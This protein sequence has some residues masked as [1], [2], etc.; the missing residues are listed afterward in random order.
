MKTNYLLLLAV[1]TLGQLQGAGAPATQRTTLRNKYVQDMSQL[2]KEARA[3][4]AKA[5]S[6]TDAAY[7]TQR[8]ALMVKR[9]QLK[10]YGELQ[11]FEF[12]KEAEK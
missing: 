6:M 4:D 7:K 2:M 9:N 3:I 5:D 8:E 1:S 10:K 12:S 11:G